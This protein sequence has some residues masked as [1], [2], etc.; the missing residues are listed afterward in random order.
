MAWAGAEDGYLA[1]AKITWADADRGRGPTGIAI[2]TGKTDCIQDFA[3][4]PKAAPWR[5]SA[6]QRGYRSSIALPL[7]DESN[8]TFGALIIYCTEVNAFTPDE[9][10]L[11]EE[12]AGDL[13]FGIMVLR[14]RIERKRAEDAL[15]AERGL[16]VSG[17]TVVF[18]WKNRE[19]WPVE[20]VSPNVADQFGYTPEDLISGKVLYAAIVHPDDLARVGAEVSAYSEQGVASYEQLYRIAHTDGRYRWIDDFTTVVRGRDGAITHYL[21]YILD[22]TDRKRAEEE[23][24]KLNEEL[25]QRVKART[26]E[27]EGKNTE[28]ARMNKI[29]V[30]RELRMAEL[31]ERI[32]ELENQIEGQRK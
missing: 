27:L 11:L 17:P 22:I 15:R 18:K 14:D 8:N 10:R 1:T 23:L 2:R 29:F 30:G 13:A 32:K 12:L 16:F 9:I 28:L 26:I 24:R 5:D 6:L 4:D 31:K 20:Y 7:K 25:E 21:G 19:G 3:E